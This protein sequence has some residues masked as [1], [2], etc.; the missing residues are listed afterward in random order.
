MDNLTLLETLSM[1][2]A[3]SIFSR[4]SYILILM[5]SFYFLPFFDMFLSLFLFN[6]VKATAE[7]VDDAVRELPDANLVRYSFLFMFGLIIFDAYVIRFKEFL[8]LFIYIYI[9]FLT[10]QFRKKFTFKL[11]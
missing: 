7:T 9:K 6:Q 2:S 5:V 4:L 1:L 10:F 8:F 3:S 11:G